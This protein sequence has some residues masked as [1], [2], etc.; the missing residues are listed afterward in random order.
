MDSKD[1]RYRG[2]GPAGSLMWQSGRFQ[3]IQEQINLAGN[4]WADG[5]HTRL[6]EGAL[7]P[8]YRS[9]CIALN[10]FVHFPDYAN[11]IG[12]VMVYKE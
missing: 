4:D 5:P 6:L 3:N 7:A 10:C 2:L 9:H 1:Q 8:G 11:L 12:N